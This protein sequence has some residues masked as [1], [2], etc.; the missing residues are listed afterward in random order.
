MSAQIA[1][2]MKSIRL[3]S[4]AHIHAHIQIIFFFI[5]N[6]CNDP[7]TKKMIFF[8]FLTQHMKKLFFIKES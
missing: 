6:F 7:E 5:M 8:F 1:L 4:L 3:L 2:C